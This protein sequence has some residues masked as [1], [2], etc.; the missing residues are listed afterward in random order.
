MSSSTT[1]GNALSYTQ[2]VLELLCKGATGCGVPGVESAANL[3][4]GIIQ[5]IKKVKENDST[6][7]GLIDEINALA[8][9]LQSA[10]DTI[11]TIGAGPDPGSGAVLGSSAELTD[12]INNMLLVLEG[13][14]A[15]AQ[16]LKTVSRRWKLIKATPNAE[17]LKNMADDVKKA[18]EDFASRGQISI[19]LLLSRLHSEHQQ[20]VIDARLARSREAEAREREARHREEMDAT[21][22]RRRFEMDLGALLDRLP[23]ADAG[24]SASIHSRH[25]G[26]L[27]G[28]RVSLLRKLDVWSTCDT[29]TQNH[30]PFY[31]LTG[32]AGTG[33]STIAYE[34]ADRARARDRLAASFFFMRGAAELSST[35]LVFPTLAWQML[36]STPDLRTQKAVEILTT[37][38]QYGTLHNI[39]IQA[40]HLFIDLLSTLPSDHHPLIIVI[41]ALDECT[42]AAQDRVQR[43]L[44][45]MMDGLAK[46][47]CPVR[48]F[49]T[50]RPELHVEDA[51]GSATFDKTLQRFRLHEVPRPDVDA[52]IKL[53]FEAEMD[54]LPPLTR[55]I[56]LRDRRDVVDDL[57]ALAAGLFIYATTLVQYLRLFIGEEILDGVSPLLDTRRVPTSALQQLD[58]LY[59]VVLNNSFPPDVRNSPVS[60]PSMKSVLG[61]IAV[62][63]DHISPRE[64]AKLT[65]INLQRGLLPTLRRLAT[66]VTFN[67]QDLEVPIRPLHA[68]F[69]DFLVDPARHAAETFLVNPFEQH[70]TLAAHSLVLIMRR[71][72][73]ENTLVLLRSRATAP[74]AAHPV[75]GHGVTAVS[76]AI[77]Y[78]CRF[79]PVHVAALRNLNMRDEDADHSVTE[80]VQ[81][82]ASSIIGA[83]C[84]SEYVVP[85]M[86]VLAYLAQLHVMAEPLDIIRDILSVADDPSVAA[87][88]S[89]EDDSE[90]DHALAELRDVVDDCYRLIVEF[91][92]AFVADPRQFMISALPQCR[93]GSKLTQQISK[94]FPAPRMVLPRDDWYFW[95]EVEIGPPGGTR[96]SS[97]CVVPSPDGAWLAVYATRKGNPN[98]SGDVRLCRLCTEKVEDPLHALF[99]CTG[100]RTLIYARRNFW[101]K[102]GTSL[103]RRA[104]AG[105][106][107]CTILQRAPEERLWIILADTK[108]TALLGD[109]AL[110]VMQIYD[111]VRPFVPS[112][113]MVVEFTDGQ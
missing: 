1:S 57:T 63:Q 55:Q 46:I 39:D 53:Y 94:D 76:S 56:L 59:T 4:L 64:L 32:G 34:V 17:R 38:L 65:G 80:S 22:A 105:T 41:D 67:E 93:S 2:N 48:V 12:R 86:E 23:H 50:S 87:C 70:K 101:A 33:K 98:L 102:C 27:Q 110:A 45:L 71:G 36:S 8:K 79:W 30:F 10:L 82:T 99:I 9:T 25:H 35:E 103:A 16:G 73:L 11:T 68:S 108:L 75:S 13:V 44:Y 49:V 52:D 40:Q 20:E 104:N 84:L 19:E 43:M 85:W 78:A 15:D 72:I 89:D 29:S 31:V 112:E 42:V 47:A 106:D 83:F 100:Q 18:K 69:A 37:H 88:S 14:K 107:L 91:S 62:L 66:V 60:G 21:E 26:A 92:P 95:T 24:Y 74:S 5:Q 111:E 61:C 109:Y 28:T 77:I 81:A 58:H 6:C 96:G 7:K 51:L 3:S 90:A 113:Q 97:T 54:K